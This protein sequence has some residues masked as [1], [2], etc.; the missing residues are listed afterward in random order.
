MKGPT[1]WQV[2]SLSPQG[3][4]VASPST[5]GSGGRTLHGKRHLILNKLSQRAAV[6]WAPAHTSVRF[7]GAIPKP[8]HLG[9]EKTSQQQGC[10]LNVSTNK[11]SENANLALSMNSNN[12]LLIPCVY[13]W[14]FSKTHKCFLL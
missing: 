4:A 5:Q 10:T 13:S 2:R 1:K 3:P 12:T 9:R 11:L 7:I 8:S 14:G 6:A